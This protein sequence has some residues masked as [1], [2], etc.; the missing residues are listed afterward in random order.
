[1]SAPCLKLP[2]AP[3]QPHRYS[4]LIGAGA[5]QRLDLHL[6]NFTV[7]SPYWSA[8]GL[9]YAGRCKP[10]ASQNFLPLRFSLSFDK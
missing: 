1:M 10:A 7:P 4:H 8:I 6:R 5:L 2:Y 3:Q 9:L